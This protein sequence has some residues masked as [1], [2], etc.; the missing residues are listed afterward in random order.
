MM[1]LKKMVEDVKEVAGLLS[2][3]G[4]AEANA[5]NISVNV[6]EFK[7]VREFRESGKVNEK[8][9]NNKKDFE[10]TMDKKFEFLKGEFIWMTA[11]GVRMRDVEKDAENL[12]VI[13]NVSDEGS[14]YRIC[15]MDEFVT[16]KSPVKNHL[17]PVLKPTSELPSHLAIHNYFR[18]NDMPER[19]ILH[20]HPTE[21]IALTHLKRFKNSDSINKLI[22]EM[23][24]ETKLFL[25]EGAGF[26]RYV[27][28]GTVRLAEL[29]LK[30]LRKHKVVFWEK[31]GCVAVGE[32]VVKAFD[33]IEVVAK[34]V[35]IYFL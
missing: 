5:G 13:V 16:V 4:W 3:L 20:T 9:I 11:A 22:W 25:P 35:R 6:T 32:N 18:E 24:P 14:R 15:S 10:Y 26:V 27:I 8:R 19:V 21:L 31:H 23:H 7:E 33:L 17:Y 29:T 2:S 30:A 34:A 12:S 28:P 1:S